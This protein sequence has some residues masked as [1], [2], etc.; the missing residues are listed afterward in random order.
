MRVYDVQ[1]SRDAPEDLVS[2]VAPVSPVS[3]VS[4][5]SPVAPVSF[6][7]PGVAALTEVG[8]MFPLVR[9]VFGVHGMVCQGVRR[10]GRCVR[11]KCLSVCLSV[12]CLGTHVFVYL[13]AVVCGSVVMGGVGTRR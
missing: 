3:P 13:C 12:L 11:A 7:S 10:V 9:A 2:S 4:P 8:E 6:A 1:S 5:G